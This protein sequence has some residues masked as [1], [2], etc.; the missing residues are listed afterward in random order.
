MISN[1]LDYE[2]QQN[3]LLIKLKQD[4]AYNN[5]VDEIIK[6][7]VIFVKNEFITSFKGNHFGTTFTKYIINKY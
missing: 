7:D 1:F 5:L 4:K 2:K 3:L 6:K